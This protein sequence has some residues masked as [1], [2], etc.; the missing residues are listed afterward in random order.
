MP[1]PLVHIIRLAD[2]FL[3]G[4][5]DRIVGRPQTV[6]LHFE[7]A[8]NT[9]NVFPVLFHEETHASPG[10]RPSIAIDGLFFLVHIF[11]K[12]SELPVIR[13]HLLHDAIFK[14]KIFHKNP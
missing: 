5:H 10:I 13:V 14:R 4:S 3:E 1:P 6:F 8:K 7:L 12:L 2:L 11:E 9:G